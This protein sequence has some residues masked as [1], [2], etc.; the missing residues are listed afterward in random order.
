ML[1]F[2]I[3]Q[4]WLNKII[5]CGKRI[6]Y[7]EAK[8]FWNKRI[9]NYFQIEPPFPFKVPIDYKPIKFLCGRKTLDAIVD[10]IEM[11]NGMDSDLKINRPVFALHFHLVK[12]QKSIQY[13]DFFLPDDV[14][15]CND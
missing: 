10:E 3:K 5:F 6:E 13:G 2:Q 15:E 9:G 4:Y 14:E 1:V 7:R 8:P 11:I 12:N